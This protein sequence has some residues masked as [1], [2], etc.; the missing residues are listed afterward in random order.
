VAA[1]RHW[2]RRFPQPFNGSI[3]AM[4]MSDDTFCCNWCSYAGA[5]MAGTMRLKVP[6]NIRVLRVMCSGRVDPMHVLLAFAS[7]A[8]GVA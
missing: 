6:H 3:G 7:G 4:R 2:Q 8:D 1:G 5:D